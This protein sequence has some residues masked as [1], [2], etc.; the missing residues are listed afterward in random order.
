MIK[1]ILIKNPK[2]Y[3]FRIGDDGVWIELNNPS[4]KTICVNL[5]PGHKGIMLDA[6]TEWANRMI[7]NEK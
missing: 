6:L 2:D 4:G 7:K 3:N 5:N 1:S